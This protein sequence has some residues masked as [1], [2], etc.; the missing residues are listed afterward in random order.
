M[1]SSAISPHSK[2]A[3]RPEVVNGAAVEPPSAGGGQRPAAA[4]V[5]ALARFLAVR[6]RSTQLVAHLSEEDMVVQSMPDASPAKWHLAH[7]TWFFERF[8]LRERKADYEAF[9]SRFDFLF[10]SYY[11]AVGARHPRP[12]RG[13]LTRPTLKQVLEYRRHVDMQMRSLLGKPLQREVDAL[14][15][16]GLAHEEQHQELLVMDALHLF[17]Q[18]A[19][20]PVFD[21]D[22]PLAAG[23]RTAEFRRSAG[24][25]TRIGA[26]TMHFAFD[27]EGPQHRVWL[28]PFAIADRLVTNG[29]WLSFMS[30]GGYQ[31]AQ[32]W[33]SDG[34]DQRSAEDW[35]APSYWERVGDRWLQMTPAGLQPVDPAAP[36]LHV[37]YFEADA[38]A[39][40]AGARLPT[41]FEWEHAVRTVQG[42]EQVYDTAWQWTSSAYA[43]YPRFRTAAGAV[44]EYNGKFMSGQMVLRGACA[45][46]PP[47]HAR[48][49]YRNFYRAGQRW[50]FSSVRLA[51]D[52]APPPDGPDPDFLSD[53]LA[54]L[55]QQPKTL[56]PKYFYDDQGSALFEAICETP[57]YYPTRTEIQMLKRI[58]PEVA[59]PL[60]DDTVLLELGSGA[61]IKTRML[62]DASPRLS[63]Y[64]PVDISPDALHAASERLR[65]DYPSLAILPQVADFTRQ[66][67]VP[68]SLEGRP[69]LAFFPG[70][71]I[72]NFEHDQALA[73]LR[74]LRRRLAPSDRL[75][76]GA[77][78]VK[79][80]AT[81]QAAYDDAAGITAAFNRNLLQRI[82]RELDG[83]FDPLSF[84][85][86]ARWNAASSRIEMHLVSTRAQ[87]ACV[88]GQ[89]FSFEEGESIHTENSHKFTRDSFTRLAGEAGWVLE[90]E[91]I[92]DAP[93]FGVFLFRGRQG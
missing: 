89:A 5:P 74:M 72:G 69:I 10:N 34:W 48:A 78:Q 65:A 82:N 41:E 49:S 26:S 58:A 20:K 27:N 19:L 59:A 28:T 6:A 53:V 70:S 84:R 80:L 7:T 67:E 33:L 32:F 36:V 38:Y 57:E 76:I 1:P 75:L 16:L 62:L 12:M 66:F 64:V 8:I 68:A 73:L 92:S 31:Q 18:S 23:G 55:A 88:A 3:A 47:G 46:T 87:V 35:Q 85:H 40:W 9:D 90:R 29:E 24:G 15:Q 56:S 4:D 14:L 37:S 52:V 79:D 83:T 60:A 2:N 61:S 39:R 44:G 81:L 54:G 77:D 45:A 43:P 22:W 71:T 42:L 11:E 21:P 86:E 50:M 25:W 51:R 63:A 13:L 93:S 91:W 30:A 17:A